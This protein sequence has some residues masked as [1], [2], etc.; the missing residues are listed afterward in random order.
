MKSLCQL[1]RSPT[2]N[3][4]FVYICFIYA[5]YIADSAPSEYL[6]LNEQIEYNAV[7]CYFNNVNKRMF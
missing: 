4:L 3:Y 1:R 6:T 5:S 2:D 7:N